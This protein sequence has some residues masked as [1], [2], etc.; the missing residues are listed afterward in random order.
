[1]IYTRPFVTSTFT[2]FVGDSRTRVLS[3]GLRLFDDFTGRPP[4]TKLRVRLKPVLTSVPP[5]RSVRG[6]S[7]AYCF[8]D[9]PNGNYTLT[10]ETEGT[11]P[12]LY[13]PTSLPI[14]IPLPAL[15]DPTL[16]LIE[17]ILKPSSAYPYPLGTTLARGIVTRLGTGD[18]V[19]DALVS[20]TYHQVDPD[21]ELLTLPANV[22]TH[23]DS[24]GQFA[25]FFRRLPAP[26]QNVTIVAKKAANQVQTQV[27]IIEG[28]TK[29][30]N[31]PGLP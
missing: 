8:E 11:T 3:L 15:L 4:E 10:I 29:T 19:P 2:A 23:S 7:G 14:T 6:A 21:D 17:I 12:P 16:P 22:A 9:V 20:S 5:P 26:T 18:P 24:D 13:V 1:M 27:V 25:L 30:V 28:N 31:L